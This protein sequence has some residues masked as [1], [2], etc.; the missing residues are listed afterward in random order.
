[1]K[2]LRNLFFNFIQQQLDTT[3]IVKFKKL[4]DEAIE[5]RRALKSDAAFDLFAYRKITITPKT[6]KL[7]EVG[8]AVEPPHW[9]CWTLRSRGSMHIHGIW[10]YNGM[11]DS[12]Y[13]GDIGINLWNTTSKPLIYNRGERVGQIQFMLR[14]NI[15][16]QEVEK[17]EDSERGTDGFGSTGR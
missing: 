13:R 14:P 9:L 5:P 6:M 4:V 8:I 15:I 12:N 3:I 7:I 1:M 16:L 10:A 17:L 11:G 2:I